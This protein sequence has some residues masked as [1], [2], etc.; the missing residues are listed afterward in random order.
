MQAAGP[1]GASKTDVPKANITPKAALRALPTPE[2]APGGKAALQTPTETP[3]DTIPARW[4]RNRG[5]M[6]AKQKQEVEYQAFLAEMKAHYAEVKNTAYS[7]HVSLY[8][9]ISK[10]YKIICIHITILIVDNFPFVF[11]LYRLTP[12]SSL[13]S[14]HP[15][16][17]KF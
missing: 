7:F 6:N 3:A 11:A 1:S 15:L 12:W 17:E 10:E 8:S 14:L 4:R 5:P 13:W 9:A 16:L 2:Q